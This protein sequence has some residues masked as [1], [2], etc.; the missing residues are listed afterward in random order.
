[1][2]ESELEVPK[3]SQNDSE[4][5]KRQIQVVSVQPSRTGFRVPGL[6]RTRSRPSPLTG[7]PGPA[8][9]GAGRAKLGLKFQKKNEKFDTAIRVQVRVTVLL[10]PSLAAPRPGTPQAEPL[11]LPLAGWDTGIIMDAGRAAC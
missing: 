5:L 10:S 2:S 9:G 4:P 1:M 6:V 11:S 3:F 7:P 8:R